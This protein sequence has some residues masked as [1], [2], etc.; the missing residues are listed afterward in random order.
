MPSLNFAVTNADYRDP[1]RLKQLAL[2]FSTGGYVRLPQLLTSEALAALTHEAA[3][4]SQDATARN[5]VMPGL[6]TPRRMKGIG[7]KLLRERSQLLMWLYDHPDVVHLISGISG[8]RAQPC[9][10][11]NEF[12]VMNIFDQEGAT[13]GWHFD[14]P[15][16]ALVIVVDAPAASQGGVLEFVSDC[17]R[18]DQRGELARFGGVTPFVEAAQADG[19][20]RRKHHCAGDAYMLRADRCLHR[21]TPVKSGAYRAILNLAYQLG[22][23]TRYG[24]TADILYDLGN[25]TEAA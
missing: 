13:H 10:H 5:F 25:G 9:S 23:E 18:K 6:M 2:Q 22:P 19:L 24:D 1:K 8:E 16:L 7:G 3:G 17:V 12:M 15:A 14:D 21:V 4:L 20:L 11:P